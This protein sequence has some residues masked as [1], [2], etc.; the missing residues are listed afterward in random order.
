MRHMRF[1]EQSAIATLYDHAANHLPDGRVRV[2]AASPV[3]PAA[4]ADFSYTELAEQVDELSGW[5]PA[6]GV[7][8]GAT[9]VIA[10]A[11]HPDIQLL[12]AAASRAGALP[13]LVSAAVPAEQARVMFARLNPAAIVTDRA[14]AAT[15][16]LGPDDPWRTILVD[17]GAG[18][19]GRRAPKGAVAADDLRGSAPAP[20]RPPGHTDPMVVTH[21]SGTTGVPKLVAH[22]AATV[23]AG[24]GW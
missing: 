8:P 10:K 17:G 12:A 11:N 22:S 16:G 13:A 9:V 2:A 19:G 15:W 5:F 3:V 14:L 6:A 7:R 18:A 20:V 21:T 24:P 4:P 1:T 23:A